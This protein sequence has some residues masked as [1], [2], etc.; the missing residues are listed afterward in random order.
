MKRLPTLV[1]IAALLGAA[2][3]GLAAVGWI[4]GGPLGYEAG[5]TVFTLGAPLTTTVFRIWIARHVVLTDLDNLWALPFLSALLTLQLV[6]WGLS[7]HFII[8]GLRSLFHK[9]A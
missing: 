8:R 6:V 9:H 1:K 4:R 5:D 2:L 3:S 7:I